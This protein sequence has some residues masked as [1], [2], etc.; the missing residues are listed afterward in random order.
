MECGSPDWLPSLVS[1]ETLSSE[2]ARSSAANTELVWGKPG[3]HWQA[4]LNVGETV[5][6]TGLFRG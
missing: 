1:P 5:E 3:Y 4:D 2:P 6:A